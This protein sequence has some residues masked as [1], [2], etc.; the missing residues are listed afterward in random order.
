[1]K[2]K[3]VDYARNVFKNIE[4]ELKPGAI[5]HVFTPNLININTGKIIGYA[6]IVELSK[7]YDYDNTLFEQ[8]K[9]RIQADECF[10][11]VNH[12]HLFVKY[13]VRYK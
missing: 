10:L 13:N 1:M 12:G 2:I 8:W 4:K 7:K 9:Q 3:S 6:V 11:Y 5:V